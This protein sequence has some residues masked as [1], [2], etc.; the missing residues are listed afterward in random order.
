M[1]RII[2]PFLLL[3]STSI[4]ANSFSDITFCGGAYCTSSGRFGN[5]F[6]YSMGMASDISE[7]RRIEVFLKTGTGLSEE[8]KFDAPNKWNQYCDSY[9]EA[10]FFYFFSSM[11]EGTNLFLGVGLGT[12]FGKRNDNKNYHFWGPT[13]ACEVRVP[14]VSSI[15]LGFDIHGIHL[16]KYNLISGGINLYYAL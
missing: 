2:I 8:H 7:N 1:K 13:Y 10:S 3:F 14:I 12:A 4:F 16:I 9:N 5:V 6:S 15:G 11:V